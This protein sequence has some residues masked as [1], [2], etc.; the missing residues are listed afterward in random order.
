MRVYNDGGAPGEATVSDTLPT[1]LT[2]ARVEPVIL[3]PKNYETVGSPSCRLSSVVS[4]TLPSIPQLGVWEIRIFVHVANDVVS[5]SEASNL[6]TVVGAG[7]A[8]PAQETRMVQFGTAI[9]EFGSSSEFGLENA[10]AWF[11]TADGTA[12]TRAGSHP[13]ELTVVYSNNHVGSLLFAEFPSGG[14][15][16]NLTV[17]L[18]PGI[19]G[20]PTA[21]PQCTRAQ[22]D[23]QGEIDNGYITNPGVR[24]MREVGTEEVEVEGVNENI[25]I[26]NL[27]PPA[28][29]PAQFAFVY[30]GGSVFLDAGADRR[31]GLWDHGAH[32]NMPQKAVILSSRRSGVSRL[33]RM[34]VACRCR[35]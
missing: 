7:A 24:P 34:G 2:A 10:D 33:R 15:M 6:V 12:D 26:Y 4:C 5:G 28:G 17:N 29:I 22:F 14:E 16:K 9:G 3:V 11:T 13:Y 19:I 21:V 30:G 8:S 18:P 1:G 25:P 32:D 27:V 23:E 35:C 31:G 20:D